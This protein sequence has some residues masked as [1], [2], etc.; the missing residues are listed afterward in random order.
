MFEAIVVMG[1]SGARG[2]GALELYLLGCCLRHVCNF[3]V[4]VIKFW[5]SD[6]ESKILK[7]V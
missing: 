2:G 3:W 1:S 5:V 6:E 4:Y 7:R